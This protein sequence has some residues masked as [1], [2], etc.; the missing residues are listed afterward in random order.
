M[1]IPF[2]DTRIGRTV[3]E[4]DLPAAIEALR[5]IAA[6]LK[7]LNAHLVQINEGHRDQRER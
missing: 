6:Q 4:R 7:L 3:L 2:F 1:S 5:E